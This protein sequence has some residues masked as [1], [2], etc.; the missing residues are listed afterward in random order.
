MG[1]CQT[2]GLR[3]MSSP[4]I[5]NRPIKRHF[6]PQL[7]VTL[8]T[9]RQPISSAPTSTQRNRLWVNKDNPTRD[10]GGIN[11]VSAMVAIW[12]H[13]IVVKALA[14]TWFIG[15]RIF[16]VKCISE[17]LT[18]VKSVYWWLDGCRTYGLWQMQQPT[19]LTSTHSCITCAAGT[20]RVSPL[21]AIGNFWH[22]KG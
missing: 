20:Q 18:G 1:G 22:R 9:W 5:W 15:I 21:S 4:Y 14:Q 17:R 19:C 3:G 12:H 10:D 6:S 13:F 2:Y 16:W 7:H 11:P 8:V